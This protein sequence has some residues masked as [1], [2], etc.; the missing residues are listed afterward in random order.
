MIFIF[1]LI[2]VV[3]ILFVFFKVTKLFFKIAIFVFIVGVLVW[4]VHP[5]CQNNILGG[6]SSTA[7]TWS[8]LPP[9]HFLEF[10]KGTNQF[11]VDD[12]TMFCKSWISKQFFL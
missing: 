4:I 2:I 6:Y 12:K 11:V 5:V 9:Q 10:L 7:V 1:P 3:V 8:T